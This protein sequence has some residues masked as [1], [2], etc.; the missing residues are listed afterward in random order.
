[1]R[2]K[3]AIFWQGVGL[4]GVS[5]ALVLCGVVSL[6]GCASN[7]VSA[8]QTPDQRAYAVYGAFVISEEQGAKVATDPTVDVHVRQA[9]QAADAKAKPS[10]DALLKAYQDYAHAQTLL[11]AGTGS[12][13][14]FATASA[15]L[16]QWIMTAEADV[17][18]LVAAVKVK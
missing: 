4:L 6:V 12:A 16:D 14:Q 15:N 2:I 10:A 1:M 8:A 3:R 5:A 13:A 7:P 11:N 17:N 18:A 9:I